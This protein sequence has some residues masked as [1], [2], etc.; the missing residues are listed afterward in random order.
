MTRYA[1]K[2]ADGYI[3]NSQNKRWWDDNKGYVLTQNQTAAKL[4]TK[5]SDAEAAVSYGNH[6]NGAG[7]VVD[8]RIIFDE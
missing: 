3:R 8:V 6:S 1:V 2:F 5:K 7:R 4:Y